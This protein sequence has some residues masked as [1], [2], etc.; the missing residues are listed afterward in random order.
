MLRGA[1][2]TLRRTFLKPELQGHAKCK[3]P[4]WRGLE[5]DQTPHPRGIRNATRGLADIVS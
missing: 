1:S 4:S 2:A 5:V 3:T